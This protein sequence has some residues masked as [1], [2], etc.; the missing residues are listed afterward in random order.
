V[1]HQKLVHPISVFLLFIL[2]LFFFQEALHSFGKNKVIYHSHTWKRIK[3]DHF[4]IYFPEEI[5]DQAQRAALMAEEAALYLSMRMNHQLSSTVPLILYPSTQDFQGTNIIPDLI[6]DGT[7]GFT[8]IMQRRVALPI[9]GSMRQ[10]RHVITHELVHVFQF[11]ILLGDGMEGVLGAPY[12]RMPLWLMEG[13]AEYYSLGWDSSVEF[14]MRDAVIHSALPTIE[15]ISRYQVPSYYAFYK[16]GQSILY[17]IGK[18][19]GDEK[20]IEIF[21]DLRDSRHD[22]N[23]IL[24]THLHL[25]LEELDWEWRQWLQRRYWPEISQGHFFNEGNARI[26]TNHLKKWVGLSF[27]P[28]P[29]PDGKK[30]AYFSNEDYYTSLMVA[31]LIPYQKK[32]KLKNKKELIRGDVNSTFESLKVFENKISWSPDGKDLFFLGKSK[33][34]EY[35]YKI[36]AVSGK[37]LEKIFLPFRS[38][39]HLSLNRK[40]NLLIFIGIRK[41]RPEIAIY[42]L[43]QKQMKIILSDDYEKLSPIFGVSDQDILFVSNENELKDK[44]FGENHLVRYDLVT[45]KRTI[46]LPAFK[47]FHSLE[48]SPDAKYLLFVSSVEGMANIYE[49]DFVNIENVRA[50][51]KVTQ[52][53]SGS[54]FPRYIGN[55]AKIIYNT[56]FIYAYDILEYQIDRKSGDH[57]LKIPDSQFDPI[58]IP[59]IAKL[60]YSSDIED[61][62]MRINPEILGFNLGYSSYGFVGFLQSNFTDLMGDYRLQ[63]TLFYDGGSEDANVQITYLDMSQRV[64][65]FA[66]LYRMKNFLNVVTIY[67]LQDIFYNTNYDAK[68]M[69]RYGF[70]AG[71]IY[72]FSKFF[73]SELKISSSRYEK[74][75]FPVFEK[76]NIAGNLHEASTAFI[77]DNT[78]WSYSY[79]VQGNRTIFQ[80]SQSIDISG[81]DIAISRF[82]ADIRQYFRFWERQSIAARF[83]YGS[84]WGLDQDLFPYEIGGFFTIRG[85]PFR[86]YSGAQMALVNL[87]YRFTFIEAI[88][89]G[90]PFRFTLGSIGGLWFLDMGAAWDRN[91]FSLFDRKKRFDTVKASYG[92]GL[93]FVLLPFLIFR[94]DFAAPWNGRDAIPMNKWQ[95]EFSI[96][97][98]Y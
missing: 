39:S 45:G 50:A 58:S 41:T 20:I 94:V 4:D 54:Y 78:I 95:G 80:Y 52:S 11:D 75:Y 8:E 48:L 74:E 38:L 23:K 61:Y 84:I 76:E 85:H 13:M 55:D 72:P 96:G 77:F 46:V 98:D 62:R 88:Q 1:K 86:E 44:E 32:E 33:G 15:Q 36:N 26:R 83:L 9:Q 87:E 34:Q 92:A 16:Y 89:F 21:L 7:G 64:H 49:A 5:F 70:F 59:G 31:D 47:N 63:T 3:T 27:K 91:Q 60:S 37:V 56:Y 25:D 12:L 22:L 97:F 65:L 42:D 71:A 51:R 6:G 69:N 93:R 30:I 82:D 81:Q 67:N 24:E 68:S 90:W 18:H 57:I 40:G 10:L 14:F 19:F 73:R 2:I 43:R 35:V 79:P 28:S 66:G 17:Y 29:S 53:L